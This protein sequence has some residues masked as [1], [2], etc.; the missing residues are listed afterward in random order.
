MLLNVLKMNINHCN[1]STHAMCQDLNFSPV[2]LCTNPLEISNK[3]GDVCVQSTETQSSYS[4][5]CYASNRMKTHKTVALKPLLSSTTTHK[6]LLHRDRELLK[7]SQKKGYE[8]VRVV[9]E[10]VLVTAFY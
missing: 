9:K 5:R 7:V 6:N 3:A 8:D 10:Y 4:P 2:M 1:Y